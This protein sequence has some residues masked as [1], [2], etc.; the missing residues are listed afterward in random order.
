LATIDAKRPKQVNLRRA[1][2]SAY[3]GL[4]HFLIDE[5]CRLVMGSRHEQSAYRDVLARAFDHSAMRDACISF[6]GGQLKASL[7]KGLPVGFSVPLAIRQVAWAFTQVQERRHLADYDRSERFLRS[8]VLARI[9][10][11]ETAIEDFNALALS[12]EKKFFLACLLAWKS[13]TR[14]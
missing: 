13:L 7:T 6:A 10:Q 11:I 1:V 2:S 5:A 12:N 4:F 9:E 14:R 8:E 3:Y